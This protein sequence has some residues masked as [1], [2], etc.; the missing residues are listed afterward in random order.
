[1]VRHTREDILSNGKN[2]DQLIEFL[3]QVL[4]ESGHTVTQS[5]EDADTQIVDAAVDIS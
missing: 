2:K 4:R 5:E 1:M 3:S